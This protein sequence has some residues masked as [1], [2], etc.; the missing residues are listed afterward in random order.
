[1][2]IACATRISA[3][4]VIAD[5]LWL[6]VDGA[7]LERI[8]KFLVFTHRNLTLALYKMNAGNCPSKSRV[9]ASVAETSFFRQVDR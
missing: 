6:P 3:V 8:V 5:L 4:N 7:D 1:M 9:S 2:H